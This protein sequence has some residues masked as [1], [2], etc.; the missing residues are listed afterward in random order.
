[1]EQSED[2]LASATK[3]VVL[4]FLFSSHHPFQIFTQD[5]DTALKLH[6]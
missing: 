5:V 4:K 1:M 2:L 6:R 3:Q